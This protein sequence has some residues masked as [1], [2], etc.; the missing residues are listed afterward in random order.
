MICAKTDA[1]WVMDSGG[2]KEA[3][4][5]LLN[6]AEISHAKGQLLGKGH[7]RACFLT[8]CRELC[9]NGGTDR[10]TVWVVDWSGPKEAHVQS[11]LPGGRAHWCN[12]VNTIELSVCDGDA[13]LCQITLTTCLVL[14]WS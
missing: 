11:Y 6:G 12:L 1:I 2:S 3:C 8:V 10:Y 9:K 13:A 14:R 4:R 5:G 7:A